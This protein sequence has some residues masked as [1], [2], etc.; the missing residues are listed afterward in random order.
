RVLTRH[1]PKGGPVC[2]SKNY[3][4]QYQNC[5]LIRKSA[6]LP[7][8]TQTAADVPSLSD[9]SFRMRISSI[10]PTRMPAKLS[11]TCSFPMRNEQL[12]ISY[13]QQTSLSQNRMQSVSTALS[14]IQENS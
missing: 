8:T 13:W 3:F 14:A 4:K 5:N 12:T 7:I 10:V 9:I 6:C 1:Q 11:G 2:I